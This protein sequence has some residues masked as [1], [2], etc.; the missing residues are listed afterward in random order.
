MLW[1]IH[2]TGCKIKAAGH[3]YL[4]TMATWQKILVFPEQPIANSCGLNTRTRG[5]GVNLI[6]FNLTSFKITCIQTQSYNT[7][8]TCNWY[9]LKDL[10]TSILKSDWISSLLR[11]QGWHSK[12][13]GFLPFWTFG[14]NTLKLCFG[15]FN[16]FPS[17]L[18][19]LFALLKKT[20]EFQYKS[21]IKS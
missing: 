13:V 14:W 6:H 5:A 17:N 12:L 2:V 8:T 16:F 4:T 10:Q 21:L 18:P 3:M 20:Q 19:N 9:E 11:K 1:I 7:H 15:F